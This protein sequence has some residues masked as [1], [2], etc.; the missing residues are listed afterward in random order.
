[1]V[2]NMKKFKTLALAAAVSAGLL[3]SAGVM[4][5][6]DSALVENGP[7]SGWFDIFLFNNAEA[8]FGVSK[9]TFLTIPTLT[10]K[11]RM[12]VYTQTLTN[13]V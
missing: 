13:S 3:A 11:A 10:P 6:Q 4:A 7:A 8:K 5:A 9:I 2:R 1:M 12:C